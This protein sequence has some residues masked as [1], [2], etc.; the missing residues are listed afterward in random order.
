[1]SDPHGA[2]VPTSR[3]GGEKWSTPNYKRKVPRLRAG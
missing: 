3:K 1:M 2:V